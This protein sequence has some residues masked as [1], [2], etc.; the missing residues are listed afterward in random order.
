MPD[1]SIV[2]MGGNGASGRLKDVWRSTDG[3]TIW[4]RLPDA[5]WPEREQHTSV[6]TRD[7]S[8]VIMGGGSNTGPKSDVWRHQPAGSTEQN[9]THTYTTPGTYPVTLQAYNAGGYNASTTV[10]YITVSA[11]PVADFMANVTAGIAPLTVA[12]TD[13]SIGS[14][15]EWVW[16]FGDGATSTEQNPVHTYAVAG[17]Y[18]VSLNASN[19]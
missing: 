8:I 6:A 5:G 15:T 4:T 12:L 9:P 16:V 17:N 19:A 10:D 13:N 2:L 7:G 14:P 3:G 1:G 18:T 11:L